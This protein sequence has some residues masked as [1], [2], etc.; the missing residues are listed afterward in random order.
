MHT[1]IKT[2]RS[3]NCKECA[4]SSPNQDSLNASFHPAVSSLSY[5]NTTKASIDHETEKGEA[6]GGGGINGNE[7]VSKLELDTLQK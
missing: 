2:E 5:P 6:G 3:L 4:L 7:I 1:H